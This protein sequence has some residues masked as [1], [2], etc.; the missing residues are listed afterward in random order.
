VQFLS[1]RHEAA[2]YALEKFIERREYDPEG[3]CWYGRVLAALGE[4]EAASRAFQTAMEAVRTMP[5][6]RKYQV[7]SWGAEARRELRALQTSVSRPA[8]MAANRS[9]ADFQ[10]A[11]KAQ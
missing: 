9:A 2:R 3:E 5:A 10:M 7:R 1:G 11:D 6:P 4:P 8:C